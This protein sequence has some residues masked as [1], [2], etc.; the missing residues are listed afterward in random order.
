MSYDEFANVHVRVKL[1]GGAGPFYRSQHQL[2]GN[3]R[4]RE[5]SGKLP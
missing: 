5:L 4:K 3:S 2:V 1:N